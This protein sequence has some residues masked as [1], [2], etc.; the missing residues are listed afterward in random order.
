VDLELE[1]VDFS[2]DASVQRLLEQ[3]LQQDQ[4]MARGSAGLPASAR[5]P[6]CCWTAAAAMT[7]PSLAWEAESGLGAV[8]R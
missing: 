1:G 8:L 6:Q 7:V 2:D 4:Q 3:D 5:S